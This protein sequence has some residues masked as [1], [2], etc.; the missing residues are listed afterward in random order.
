MVVLSKLHLLF[1][2][3]LVIMAFLKV[4]FMKGLLL[5]L[6]YFCFKGADFL[7]VKLKVVS[8]LSRESS[9]P[10]KFFY[11]SLLKTFTIKILITVIKEFVTF[12]F[13]KGHSANRHFQF[14]VIRY[15]RLY[16]AR[17]HKKGSHICD[18]VINER[19]ISTHVTSSC[20]DKMT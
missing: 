6:R 14:M 16:S 19:R 11:Q 7:R 18:N 5:Y 10:D 3:D 2:L 13:G 4:L 9:V 15:S 17:F 8:R 1:N 12:A 20:F